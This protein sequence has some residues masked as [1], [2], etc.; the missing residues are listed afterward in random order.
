VTPQGVRFTAYEI[1]VGTTTAL[2]PLDPFARLSDGTP[3]GVRHGRVW[4]TY[5]H[6]ALESSAVCSEM[7]RTPMP[8]APPKAADYAAL[9]EWFGKY[10]D[11]P[12]EWIPGVK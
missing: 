3:E 5:L 2:Q 6:G 7:F 10:A 12:E 8:L 11:A 9:A 1:H 4:G